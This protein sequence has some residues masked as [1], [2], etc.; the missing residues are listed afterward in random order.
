M[1]SPTATFENPPVNEV[2]VAAYFDPP[3][4]GL[5]SEHIGLLWGKFKEDFPVVNQKMPDFVISAPDEPCSMPRYWFVAEDESSLVQ[6]QKNAFIFNWRRR[7][8]K[9]PGFRQHIKP[10]F[11]KHYDH[12]SEFIRGELHIKDPAVGF[13]QL[14]YINVLERSEYWSGP[15]DTAKVIPAFSVMKSNIDISSPEFNC[16]HVYKVSADLQLRIS[17]RTGFKAQQPSVP[18]LA[19][20][21]AAESHFAEPIEKPKADKWFERAHDAIIS[22]FWEMTSRDIQKHLWKPMEVKQ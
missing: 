6:I 10:G 13:C 5:R 8:D 3:L 12:F 17:I 22:Y 1:K 14:A 11:D 19:F 9:Y 18:V 21:I 16:S 2:V 7:E 4:F 15:E 20:D